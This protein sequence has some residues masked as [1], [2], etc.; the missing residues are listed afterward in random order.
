MDTTSRVRTTTYALN[1]YPAALNGYVRGWFTQRT[2]V[3]HTSTNLGMVEDNSYT[4]EYKPVVGVLYKVK[5]E[6]LPELDRREVN[7]DRKRVDE[8][9]IHLISSEMTLEGYDIYT[10]INKQ[11][12]I[13]DIPALT[14]T[15]DMPMVQTYVD[16]CVNGCI[17]MEDR[18][19]PAKIFKF[20]EM[21]FKHTVNWSDEFWVNDRIHPR[22]PSQYCPNANQIDGLIEKYLD[23]EVRNL[24]IE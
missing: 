7:F 11:L 17:E 4:K 9:Q 18:F 23:F 15:L 10:Y 21:F 24:K 13:V 19:I 8:K 16:M 20:K 2:A 22:R 1:A 12:T 3:G 6:D 5:E 14:P